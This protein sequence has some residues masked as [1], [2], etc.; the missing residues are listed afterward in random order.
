[1]TRYVVDASVVA[2]WFVPEVHSDAALRIL[3]DAHELL[4]PDLLVPEVGNVLWKKVRLGELRGTESRE[5]LAVFSTAPVEIHRS[6][7]LLELAFEI[8]LL[9]ARTVYDSLYL[10][11]AT[12]HECR[13]I[14][15]DRKL[16]RALRA[17][18]FASHLQWV[19]DR[20]RS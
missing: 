20:P 13:L 6:T 14:T 7:P 2:K 15:A 1:M 19:E 8:A 3:D 5:I 11:L 18:G 9:T 10:A 4:A 12:V 16:Y 17:G